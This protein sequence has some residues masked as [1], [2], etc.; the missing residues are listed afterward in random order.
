MCSLLSAWIQA[1]TKT[2]PFPCVALDSFSDFQVTLWLW[3]EQG[4][5]ESTLASPKF[6]P[7]PVHREKASHPRVVTDSS[8]T[9]SAFPA[10]RVDVVVGFC[11]LTGPLTQLTS[12]WFP[13]LVS[14]CRIRSSALRTWP[15]SPP[16]GMGCQGS[17]GGGGGE[18]RRGRV[19]GGN[20]VTSP[21]NEE[22]VQISPS[23][24]SCWLRSQQA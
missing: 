4:I 9:G 5:H 14:S 10:A 3:G 13:T 2:F 22:R 16:Y 19:E 7:F 11:P 24:A 20:L 6:T 17:G 15:V 12:G 8:V 1:P 18:Q 21:K 23:L